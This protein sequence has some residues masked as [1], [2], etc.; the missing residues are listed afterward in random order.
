MQD[1]EFDQLFNSKLEYFEVE[2]SAEVWQNIANKLEGKKAARSIVPYLSIAASVIV[3][4]SVSLWFFNRTNKQENQPHVKLVRNTKPIKEQPTKIIITKPTDVGISEKSDEINKIASVTISEK[5]KKDVSEIKTVV[6]QEAVNT[7]DMIV[8]KP[9]PVLAVVPAEKATI[10]L[11]AAPG[12]D[13]SSGTI[14]LVNQPKKISETTESYIVDPIP[15][16]I[17]SKKKAHGLGGI[18]NTIIAAVDKRD[19]KIIEFSDADNDEG[20]RVT[21]VNLGIFK[22]KKPNNQ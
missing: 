22:I 17:P 13:I 6:K 4:A 7:T 1:K 18:F 12:A 3:L 19:D 10:L 2:P 5:N 14:A 9:E 11:P 15:E 21:G 20:S 8:Q 16:K